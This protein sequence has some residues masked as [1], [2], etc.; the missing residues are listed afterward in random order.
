[1]RAGAWPRA[2][3]HAPPAAGALLPLKAQRSVCPEQRE[4]HEGIC[5][6]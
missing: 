1:M 5:V 6:N 2:A 4:E 3:A